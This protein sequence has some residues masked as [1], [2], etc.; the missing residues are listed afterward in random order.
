VSGDDNVVGGE[1][2][3]PITFVVS[4]VSEENTSGGPGCQF[5]SGFDG[6]IRIAG[7]TEHAQVLIGGGNSMEGEVWTGRADRLGGEAVQQICGGVEP[8]Y[9]V[10]SRNRSLKEQGTQHI[11][12]G[13]ND[14]FGFTILRRSVGTR[15]PQKDPFGGE[16]CAR[17]GIVELTAIVTLDG[18]DGAA[19]LC[20]DISEKMLQGEKS[21]RFSAQR[22]SPHKM[23]VILKDNQI[24]FVAGYANNRRSP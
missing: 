19:K 2:K 24:I 3:T 7:T 9:P 1:I 16:E 21:V 6:E 17:G 4:G 20:G 22:K 18:F 10:A 23:G 5:V 12:D 11:I 13:A 15:H 14:A 8:F